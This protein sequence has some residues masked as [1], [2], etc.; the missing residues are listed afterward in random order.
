MPVLFGHFDFGV[1]LSLLKNK[2][3]ITYGSIFRES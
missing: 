3:G 2:S 1:A